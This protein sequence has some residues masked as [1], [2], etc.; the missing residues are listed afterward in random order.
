[1]D[2]AMMK[3][4][5]G[6]RMKAITILCTKTERNAINNQYQYVEI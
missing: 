1:M 5:V 6:V 3:T 2:G 4:A